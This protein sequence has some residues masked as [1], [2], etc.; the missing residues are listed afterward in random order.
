MEAFEMGAIRDAHYA[1]LLS[2]LVGIGS[3]VGF[4]VS[5]PMNDMSEKT[6]RLISQLRSHLIS[7][8]VVIE[9]PGTVSVG[10][11]SDR[12]LYRLDEFVVDTL[13]HASTGL[14]AWTNPKLPADLHVLRTDG[15]TL[16]G[17]LG[18]HTESWL[19][20][21]ADE[22]EIIQSRSG[23]SHLFDG[24]EPHPKPVELQSIGLIGIG[25]GDERLR[26]EL[27]PKLNELPA[28][29]RAR[30]AGYLSDGHLV[31]EET[32]RTRDVFGETFETSG[33]RDLL[34]DGVG[35]WRR[36]LADYVR[37]YGLELDETSL[38]RM[39]SNGWIVPHVE[40][41]VLID[42]ENS[43]DLEFEVE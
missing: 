22:R 5:R 15:S 10:H 40:T 3:S 36:D 12:Y 27:M 6:H 24:P 41:A 20:V 18:S 33:G 9:W 19:I 35:L 31:S 32:N 42:I 11:V 17:S 8:E 43:I 26:A 2:V 30:V 7:V 28:P 23:L 13:V 38:A 29:Q 39:R 1:D 16:M 25:S 4:V 37:H 21:T 14:S 34:T